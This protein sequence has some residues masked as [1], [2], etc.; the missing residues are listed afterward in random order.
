MEGAPQKQQADPEWAREDI[1]VGSPGELSLCPEA[2]D[3][4]GRRWGHK[5]LVL[6][7]GSLRDFRVMGGPGPPHTLL[8]LF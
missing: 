3:R 4:R 1:E 6:E 7:A 2:K 8:Q 5:G